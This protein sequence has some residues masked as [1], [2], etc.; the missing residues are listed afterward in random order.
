M[1]LK[2]IL[3]SFAFVFCASLSSAAVAE[4][5]TLGSVNDNVKKH[6]ARF[7]PLAEELQL[8]LIHI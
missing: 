7:T 1:G 2:R 5:L 4:T 8:S 3:S 6:L